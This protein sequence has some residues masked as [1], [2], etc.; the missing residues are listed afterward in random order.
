MESNEADEIE[1]EGAEDEEMMEGEVDIKVQGT[2]LLLPHPSPQVVEL[3]RVE[4]ELGRQLTKDEEE[5]VASQLE[6]KA[7]H[8][9]PSSATMQRLHCS[10]SR[11]LLDFPVQSIFVKI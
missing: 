6:Q 4:R 3:Q 1:G 8:L 10:R 9:S 7:I 2:A 11:R 5:F